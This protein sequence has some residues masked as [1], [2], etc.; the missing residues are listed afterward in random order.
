MNAL[1]RKKTL[2]KMCAAAWERDKKQSE[3]NV[4]VLSDRI[5]PYGSLRQSLRDRRVL[6][7]CNC[8]LCGRRRSAAPFV[9]PVSSARFVPSVLFVLCA[10]RSRLAAI[11]RGL[12]NN[13]FGYFLFFPLFFVSFPFS[14]S[15]RYR[16]IKRQRIERYAEIPN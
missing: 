9:A 15:K 12:Q 16:V 14:F 8:L 7:C 3:T 2:K 4:Y 11:S 10:L 13:F 6:F 5:R 1:P